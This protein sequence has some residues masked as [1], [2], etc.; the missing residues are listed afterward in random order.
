MGNASFQK[1]LMMLSSRSSAVA[2]TSFAT[3]LRCS[4]AKTRRRAVVN[5]IGSFVGANDERLQA[6]RVRVSFTPEKAT[7]GH[8]PANGYVH[9]SE[10]RL[11]KSSQLSA[12]VPAQAGAWSTVRTLHEKLAALGLFVGAPN[13]AAC[14]RRAAREL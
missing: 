3:S 4:K 5:N 7:C 10:L 14:A 12:N 9:P 2:S 8:A 11:S 6:L 1:H 13:R